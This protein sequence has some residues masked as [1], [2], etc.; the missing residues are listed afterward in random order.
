LVN[1]VK[2]LVGS[3][4]DCLDIKNFGFTTAAV[5]LERTKVYEMKVAMLVLVTC[6]STHH[7]P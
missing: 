2:E 3:S 6:T 7:C 4:L 1:T 5:R